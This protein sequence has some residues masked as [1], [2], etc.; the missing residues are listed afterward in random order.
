ML[1]EA[2]AACPAGS[3][4]QL[5]GERSAGVPEPVLHKDAVYAAV[6]TGQYELHDYIDF[7]PWFRSTLLQVGRWSF[8]FRPMCISRGML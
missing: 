3:A 6:G 8:G 7:T 2:E 5:A 1:R 4:S